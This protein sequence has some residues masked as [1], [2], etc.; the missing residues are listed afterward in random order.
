MH[1][2]RCLT[3]YREGFLECA[4]CKLPLAFGEAPEKPTPEDFPK[5]IG[6]L[7]TNDNFAVA[8]AVTALQQ[9]EIIFDVVPIT[10]LPASLRT[11]NPT[12]WTPPTEYWWQRRMMLK[13]VCWLSRSS[14]LFLIPSQA[15]GISC[16]RRPFAMTCS[17]GRDL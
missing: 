14:N 3:K 4:D 15:N 7:D 16:P 12:W 17:Y 11:E 1:C 2:P 13:H 8:S 10:D 6:V 9:A 5:L